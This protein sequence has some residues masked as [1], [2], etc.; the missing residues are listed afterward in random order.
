MLEP[1]Q[2]ALI[3]VGGVILVLLLLV[4]LPMILITMPIAEK[5]Y[6]KQWTR[7]K[8]FH[9]DRGCSDATVDYHLDMYN[10][11]I[12]WR[13]ENKK[14]IKEVQ[15]VSDG[16]KLYGEYYDF[17]NKKAIM[18]LPGRTETCFY[19][20]Y[21]APAFKAA[22]YNILLTDPRGHG[23]S[24][25]DII[26]LGK[27]EGLDAINWCKFLHDEMKVDSIALYGLCGGATACCV[28]LTHPDCP[29]YINS[30]IADG[31]FYSFF[32]VYKR[33][34]ID[35]KHPVYPVIWEVLGKIK[36]HNG[37]DPYKVTPKVLI[38]NVK[39]PTLL[40]SGE[41]DKF[42]V[43]EEAKKL[44]KLSGASDKKLVY[45]PNARHSHLRYDNTIDYDKAVIDFLKSH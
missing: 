9:F 42:A 18:L 4:V 10:Q 39:V 20:C 27:G 24:D 40:L 38:K 31:M 21:Y 6:K 7:S 29:N 16:L 45:I 11:G 25:G 28:A 14:Y 13:E 44:L 3:I 26:T 23:L 43:P 19:G 17:G 35:E 34:I 36:K 8:E 2:L 15:I 30:L 22:G 1:W 32:N 12:A 5:L 37:V 33:H 41:K